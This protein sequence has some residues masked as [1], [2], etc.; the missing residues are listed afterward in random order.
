MGSLLRLKLSQRTRRVGR[1]RSGVR[2]CAINA[3][4]DT[5]RRSSGE[6]SYYGPVGAFVAAAPMTL[7][8]MVTLSLEAS[9]K[10]P[11]SDLKTA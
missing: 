5:L 4:P 7:S 3:R 11:S 8:T 2:N 10:I 6:V 9:L 1:Q